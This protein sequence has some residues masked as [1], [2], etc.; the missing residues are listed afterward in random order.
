MF[1]HDSYLDDISDDYIRSLHRDMHA[2]EGLPPCQCA[3]CRAPETIYDRC[4]AQG[5]VE[6]IVYED[7]TGIDWRCTVCGAEGWDEVDA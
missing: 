5:H 1:V 6:E 4:F 7:E 3:I 2:D